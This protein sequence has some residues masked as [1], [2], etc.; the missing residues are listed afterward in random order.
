MGLLLRVKEAADIGAATVGVELPGSIPSK[1]L[2][3]S[4]RIDDALRLS[5]MR[6]EAHAYRQRS[7]E[8]SAPRERAPMKETSHLSDF[9]G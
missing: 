1:E 6:G 2:D 7:A 3:S 9:G 8:P 5:L 4:E